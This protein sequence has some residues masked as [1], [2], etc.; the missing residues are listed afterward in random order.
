MGVVKADKNDH[1]PINFNE[2]SNGG[3][4]DYVME[5]CDAKVWDSGCPSCHL[6]KV[7]LLPTCSVMEE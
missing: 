2:L 1:R 7:D 5:S 3:V 6:N 4:H